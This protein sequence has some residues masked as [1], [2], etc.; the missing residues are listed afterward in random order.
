MAIERAYLPFSFCATARVS[1]RFPWDGGVP[2]T[3]PKALSRVPNG[4]NTG[5]C[6]HVGGERWDT[7]PSPVGRTSMR[8]PEVSHRA[9]DTHAIVGSFLP[10][11][12]DTFPSLGTPLHGLGTWCPVSSTLRCR[13]HPHWVASKVPHRIPASLTLGTSKYLQSIAYSYGDIPGFL[14]KG[15]REGPKNGKKHRRAQP[16][17]GKRGGRAVPATRYVH[18]NH[19]KYHHPICGQLHPVQGAFHILVSIMTNN[20]KS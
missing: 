20:S 9:W 7:G 2:S 14:R 18:N 12:W 15:G 3:R 4:R 19:K 17:K 11:P 6:L 8:Y 5:M 13:Y 10:P 1:G 16:G